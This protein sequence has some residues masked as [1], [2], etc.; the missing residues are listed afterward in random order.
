MVKE[1][2]VMIDYT[3]RKIVTVQA[4]SHAEAIKRAEKRLASL[5]VDLQ[6]I[7]LSQILNSESNDNGAA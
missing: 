6:E 3:A 1:Y 2:R 7:E 4:S 5:Q